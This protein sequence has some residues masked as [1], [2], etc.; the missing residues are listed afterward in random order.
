MPLTVYGTLADKQ[1]AIGKLGDAGGP[2]MMPCL[3][4]QTL[5]DPITEA[6]VLSL[7]IWVESTFGP[8][9]ANTPVEIHA[10]PMPDEPGVHIC[11]ALMPQPVGVERPDCNPHLN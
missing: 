10:A 5:P 4:E 3:F 7:E 8:W 6:W 11:T 9:P 1:A 2:D